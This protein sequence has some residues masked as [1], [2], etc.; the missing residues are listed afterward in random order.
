MK[1]NSIIIDGNIATAKAAY[2]F[3]EVVCIFPIT[4][5][6]NASYQIQDFSN[7]ENK[8]FSNAIPIV[9]QYQ[10]EAGSISG[11]HGALQMGIL[12]TTFTSSQGLLLMIPGINKCKGQLLPAVIHVATRSIAN[13]ALSIFGDHQDI[14]SIRNIGTIMICSSNPQKCYYFALISH[15]IA[16]SASY[17]VIHFYD[18][19]RT[20]NEVRQ[21]NI[22]SNKT[23]LKFLNLPKLEEFRKRGLSNKKPT[24]RGI[25]LDDQLYFQALESQNN[26][27]D[28]MKGI[29]KK[30]FSQLS[31]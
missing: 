22:F 6:S 25:H 12:A 26:H 27:I 9:F 23:M 10:S 31:I 4:P 11:I 14:Y 29:V 1:K 15:A 30:Y 17:S 8:N 21:V 16:I 7:K 19:F 3:S 5:S 13:V 28:N 20:S 18:G 24:I 2:F